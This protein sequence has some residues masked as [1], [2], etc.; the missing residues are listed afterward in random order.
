M[1][2][3]DDENKI[4]ESFQEVSEDKICLIPDNRDLN[5]VF[6]LI[7]NKEEWKNG[8]IHQVK[9]HHRLIFIMKKIR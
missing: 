7:Y 8:L 3:Y 6:K 2:I 1:G 5:K 4:I 9:V